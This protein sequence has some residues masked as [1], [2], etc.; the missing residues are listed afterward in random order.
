[1]FPIW[2]LFMHKQIQNILLTHY[3]QYNR[4]KSHKFEKKMNI[5]KMQFFCQS[6]GTINL[7]PLTKFQPT[8]QCKGRSSTNYKG[9]KQYDQH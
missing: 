3:F 2:K 7:L 8:R 5:L 6:L 1:M 9:G 4:K